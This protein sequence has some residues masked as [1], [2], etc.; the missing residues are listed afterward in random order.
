ML[1]DLKFFI[2]ILIRLNLFF[3]V[4][5]KLNLF[6]FDLKKIIIAI[7]HFLMLFVM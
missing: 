2:T 6:Y 1:I 3:L 7:N 4:N 5:F